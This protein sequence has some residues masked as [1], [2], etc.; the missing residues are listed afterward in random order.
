M[1]HCFLVVSSLQ[2]L[3][4][5]WCGGA[6]LERDTKYRGDPHGIDVC[7][8]YCN[9]ICRMQIIGVVF[10]THLEGQNIEWAGERD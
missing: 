1:K 5:N 8:E 4:Q 9:A 3:A 6:K 2:L 10:Y 7:K